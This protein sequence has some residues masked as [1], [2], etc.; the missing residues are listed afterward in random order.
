MVILVA[1]YA[2]LSVDALAGDVTVAD[3][4]VGVRILGNVKVS[5][6]LCTAVGVLGTV[7]GL[8]QRSLRKSTT[9][10]LTARIEDLERRIDPKR[11]TS[12]LTSRGDTPS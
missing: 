12:G 10:R 6:I 8:Q 9:E 3:I 4:G 7:Y 11:S 5:T 1:R 2:Y